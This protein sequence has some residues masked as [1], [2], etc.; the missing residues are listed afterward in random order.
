MFW[1]VWCFVAGLPVGA[2][3]ALVAQRFA[4]E[5]GVPSATG[6]EIGALVGGALLLA[7][8][9]LIER[10]R[11]DDPERGLHLAVSS[12]VG[13]A[14][15][16]ALAAALLGFPPGAPVLFGAVVVTLGAALV[17][18]ARRRGPAGG[19]PRAAA[20]AVAAVGIALIAVVAYPMFRGGLSPAAP[21]PT[22]GQTAAVFDLDAR[23]VT[24]A[25][26]R[27]GATPGGKRVLADRGAHPRLSPDGAYVWTDA[28]TPDGTRQIHRVSI[29]DGAI[30]CWTCGEKGNNVRPAPSDL[31][32]GVLFDT[33]R[34]VTL[35]EPTNTE[36]HLIGAARE[37]AGHGSRR[38]TVS[39]G[40]DDHALFGPGSSIVV[41]SQGGDGRYAVVS[42]ALRSGHGGIMLGAG[43]VLYDG[44]SRWTAPLAWSPDARTLVV[45]RGNPLRPLEARL[46]DLATGVEV[47]AGHDVPGTAT[48]SFDA[49][50]GWLALPATERASVAG[51]LP[52]R[53]G[54][55]VAP[56]ANRGG[57]GAPRF[58]TTA[59]RAGEPWGE[60]AAIALG[61][62][63]TWGEPTGVALAADGQSFVLGQRRAGEAGVE[64]RLLHVSL[65]CVSPG[66]V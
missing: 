28:A 64:E 22:P 5:S 33:D 36:I 18:G 57:S 30:E 38:L 42:G 60:G 50:G 25:L 19:V 23:V 31:G 63:A 15:L 55:L 11:D 17:R 59:V 47:S 1:R 41:W 13:F 46:V 14:A 65:D 6:L 48:A 24:R 3:G 34:W 39:P 37:D 7:V 45:V 29:A 40:S 8:A 66:G 4:S 32:A 61:D 53:L 51:L 35:A 44:G 21:A 2:L 20:M 9:T 52:G 10:R 58:R 12:G 54:F 49:D 56:F 43:R 27:C 26:P 62:D 16:P